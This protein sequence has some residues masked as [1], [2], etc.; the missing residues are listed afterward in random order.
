MTEERTIHEDNDTPA[1]TLADGDT[2]AEGAIENTPHLADG[3]TGGSLENG[4]R[5]DTKWSGGDQTDDPKSG[6]TPVHAAPDEE[7]PRS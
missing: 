4:V 7:S 5:A 1:A 3:A 6:G 2:Q